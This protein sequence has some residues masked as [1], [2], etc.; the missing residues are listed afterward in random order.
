MNYKDALCVQL[1][2]PLEMFFPERGQEKLAKRAKEVC[3]RCPEQK[4]CLEIVFTMADSM[5]T[6]GIW[7]QTSHADRRR[8]H[9]RTAA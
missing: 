9:K 8:L 6:P 3:S 2:L 7:G 5:A 4:A 1:R